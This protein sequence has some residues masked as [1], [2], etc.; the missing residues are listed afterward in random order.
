MIK[1]VSIELTNQ[2]G[3]QCFFC[4]NESNRNGST[5]WKTDELVSLITDLSLNGVEAVSFG[6]GEPLEYSGIFEVLRQTRGM[7]FRSMTTNGLPLLKDDCFKKLIDSQPDKIHISLH[8]PENKSEVERIT[9]QVSTI[10]SKGILAGINLLIRNENIVAARSAS[11]YLKANG[12]LKEQIVYLPMRM[13]NPVHSEVVKFVAND[14]HFQSIGCLMNCEKSERF[15]S[16]SWNKKVAWCSYTPAK[17][18]L[19]TLDFAGI[20]HELN[21]LNLLYCG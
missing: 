12:I 14:T 13:K 7:L 4:Y 18:A 17:K 5:L 10:A 11:D 16:I 21:N 2:C 8:F 6:G 15:C 20:Q 3:K 19:K 9:H 1:L